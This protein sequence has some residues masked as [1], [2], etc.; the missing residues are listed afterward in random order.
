[1]SPWRLRKSKKNG[2]KT[3]NAKSRRNDVKEHDRNYIHRSRGICRKTVFVA[4]VITQNTIL[5]FWADTSGYQ[6]ELT[7]AS[8]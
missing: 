1:M 5:L 6:V 4:W 3:S 2:G 8:I 7:V